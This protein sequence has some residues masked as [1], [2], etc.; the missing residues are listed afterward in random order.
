MTD[1]ANAKPRLRSRLWFDNPDNPDMTALY[2][3]RYLN[4]GLTARGARS[5]A[6]RS[7]ASRRPAATS[8]PATAIT[9]SS[10]SAC[11]TAFA[12]PAASRSSFRVHPIAGDG[13]AAD[14]GAR[15]QPRLSR[16]RRDPLRLSARRRRAH[17][18]LRQDHARLPDGGRDGEHSGD[19]A[20]RRPDAQRLARR[21]ARRLGHH[22]SGRRAA[23]RRPGEIDYEE[24]IDIVA[25]SA[26]S[27]GHCNTMG[28]ASTMNCAGRGARHVA[29]GLRRDPGAVSRA[30]ADGLRDRPAH[31]RDGARGPEAVGHPDPRGLRERDRRL[32][33]DRRL[34]QCADPHQSPSRAHAASS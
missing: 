24:F 33:G 25:A 4:Y 21:R 16:A 7:S 11:A 28:T 5:R 10:R 30:R 17:H 19:R 18:R 3:E 12:T 23:L 8:R 13:Q 31:R 32:F 15:P 1:K 20:V 14:R 6:S 22:R 27:V 26:P 34:D 9:S 29:A 2:L